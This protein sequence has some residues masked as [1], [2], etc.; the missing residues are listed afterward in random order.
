MQMLRG[1]GIDFGIGLI[2]F[3]KNF[4]AN[5]WGGVLIWVMVEKMFLRISMQMP[6]GG[7]L[8]LVLV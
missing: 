8:I 6:G 7:V 4:N 5:V 1:R 3:V 2:D